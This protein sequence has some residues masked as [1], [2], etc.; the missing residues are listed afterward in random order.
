MWCL[1]WL[2]HCLCVFFVCLFL[3]EWRKRALPCCRFSC[4]WRLP[5]QQWCQWLQLRRSGLIR[6]LK[7][8][9]SYTLGALVSTGVPHPLHSTPLFP[10]CRHR[11]LHLGEDRESCKWKILDHL[12]GR[13]Q[14]VHPCVWMKT[15]SCTV[16]HHCYYCFGATAKRFQSIESSIKMSLF[17][18]G[19]SGLQILSNSVWEGGDF[20]F[21]SDP[22]K[23][24]EWLNDRMYE[25]GFDGHQWDLLIY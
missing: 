1:Q 2:P 13:V 23:A 16:T 19:Q 12:Q 7:R 17:P 6:P 24:A 20:P 14:Y 21:N 4:V 22:E 25:P 11:N 15:F 10:P 18:F 3:N 5:L 8:T 9:L